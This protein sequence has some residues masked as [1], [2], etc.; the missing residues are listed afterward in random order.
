MNL[1]VD[2]YGPLFGI[3]LD[4]SNDQKLLSIGDLINETDTLL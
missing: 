1:E 3:Y 4:L 2:K